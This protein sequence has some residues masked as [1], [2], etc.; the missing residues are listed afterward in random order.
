M[1]DRLRVPAVPRP[2]RQVRASEPEFITL[3]TSGPQQLGMQSSMNLDHLVISSLLL[4]IGAGIL[5]SSG[6]FELVQ[7]RESR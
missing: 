1:D 3:R 5:N 7:A 2:L 6:N 4:V